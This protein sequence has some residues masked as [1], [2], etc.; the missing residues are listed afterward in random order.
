MRTID[1]LALVELLASPYAADELGPMA[2]TAGVL[3]ELD[4]AEPPPAIEPGA[5]PVVIIGL[6][7]RAD[8]R[9]QP[10]PLVDACV[11]PGDPLLGAM[12]D[13]I[14][15]HP[16]ASTA[17]AVLL[18]DSTDRTVEAGLA[19][20]SA[21]YSTLQA[22]PE[23]AAWRRGG[24]HRPAPPTDAAPVVV[25]R[26]GDELIVTLDRPARHNAFS[27]GLRD[28]L[29]EA[30]AIAVLDPGVTAVHLRGNGPSFCSGGDLGEFGTFPDPASA[31]AT[32]LAR[33]PARL[34]HR[35][36]DRLHVHL[37][38]ACMGAG[39]ELPAFAA[40][41]VAAPDTRIALPELALGLVP[42]AGGTVSLPRRI[43]R[44]RSALLGLSG[45]T[46]DAATAHRWGLVDAVA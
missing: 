37:H 23:F 45:T 13:S 1:V 33:S 14:E 31:H 12:V 5:L 30:L 36:R 44:H 19:A 16:L 18:R 40:H 46:L 27:A 28:A 20:E 26:T 9:A 10:P 39:I 2:G 24:T 21:V 7:N 15:R 22:G 4:A 32:R 25:T 35:L 3:V 8:V 6:S 34:A 43:G 38:G 42:G 11:A 17:F 29:C 41:V